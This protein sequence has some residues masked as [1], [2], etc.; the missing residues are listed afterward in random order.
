MSEINAEGPIAVI[1]DLPCDQQVQLNSFDVRVEVA[2]SKHFLELARFYYRS[3]FSSCKG[4]LNLCDVGQPIPKVF[5]AVGVGH[6]AV[7][8]YWRWLDKQAQRVDD[9]GMDRVVNQRLR[10]I[11]VFPVQH[12]CG[13][14]DLTGLTKYLLQSR[15]KELYEVGKENCQDT[16]GAVHIWFCTRKLKDFTQNSL[17][18]VQ[19]ARRQPIHQ[20]KRID[21]RTG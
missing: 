6:L 10:S 17:Q 15:R 3:A 12:V 20:D 1:D 5:Y 19:R 18:M 7:F 9:S 11:L 4:F 13:L 21:L 16:K 2:P 14:Y 8:Q